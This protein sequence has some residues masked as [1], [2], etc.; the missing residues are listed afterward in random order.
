MGGPAARGE[1]VYAAKALD[2]RGISQHNPRADR[3]RSCP[4]SVLR[5]PAAA[6]GRPHG[7][8]AEGRSAEQA[9]TP[10]SAALGAHI[11]AL[12]TKALRGR[13]QQLSR[14]ILPAAPVWYSTVSCCRHPRALKPSPPERHTQ[15][16]PRRTSWTRTPAPPSAATP[17]PPTRWTTWLA[18]AASDG[19]TNRPATRWPVCRAF[20]R[21]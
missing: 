7:G 1:T 2:E 17:Y 19:T 12:E 9:F 4:R 5:L 8:E 20:G 16:E 11:L 18:T 14:H 15:S 21:E 6:A 10:I 13:Q 3:Q